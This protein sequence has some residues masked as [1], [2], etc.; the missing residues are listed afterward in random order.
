M[1]LDLG[2]LLVP[3][4]VHAPARTGN[5]GQDEQQKPDEDAAEQAD[6]PL[7]RRL[8]VPTDRGDR[9][10]REDGVTV[11]RTVPVDVGAAPHASLQCRPH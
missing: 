5:D 11:V 1:R 3:P 2:H 4:E 9:R 7:D 6:M 10:R 8:L